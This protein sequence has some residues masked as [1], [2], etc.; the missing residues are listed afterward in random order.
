MTQKMIEGDKSISDLL[1]LLVSWVSAFL[2]IS[3][4]RISQ[5]G[6]IPSL[7]TIIQEK[8]ALNLFGLSWMPE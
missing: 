5:V 3:E 7:L 2:N 6:N 4:F 8:S 1:L